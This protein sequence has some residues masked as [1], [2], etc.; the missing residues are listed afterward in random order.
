METGGAAGCQVP[1]PSSG[2]L[3]LCSD[4]NNLKLNN[5]RLHRENMSLPSNLQLNDLKSDCRGMLT[6]PLQG[7][8]GSPSLAFLGTSHFAIRQGNPP[9]KCPWTPTAVLNF[10]S[11]STAASSPAEV[12]A[13]RSCTPLLVPKTPR[14]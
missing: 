3:C 4:S 11:L 1:P 9:S 6:Y 5:V 14:G 13:T 10:R 2:A 7:S 12:P 8:S